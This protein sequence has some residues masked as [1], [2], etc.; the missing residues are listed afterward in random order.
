M[1]MRSLPAR[2]CVTACVMLA[3]TLLVSGCADRL[4]TGPGTDCAALGRAPVTL[5]DADA[6]SDELALWLATAAEVCGW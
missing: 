2:R 3:S 1:R 5:H 6:V 4:S